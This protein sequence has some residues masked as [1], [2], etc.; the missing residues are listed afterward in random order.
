MML[1]ATLAAVLA[2][3]ATTLPA[4]ER[5]APLTMSFLPPELSQRNL[6]NAPDEPEKV[7]DLTVEGGDLELTDDHRIRYLRQDIRNYQRDD[8]DR[9]FD[10]VDALIT[11]LAQIDGGF[12][13]IDEALARI[14][15]HLHAGRLSA[16]E[17]SG[18]VPELAQR[19]GQMSNAQLLQLSWYY[20]DGVGVAQ[21]PHFAEQLLRDAAYGGHASALLEI[22]RLQMQG[23]MI[24]GW[25][26][27]LDLTV[28]MA[29]GGILGDMTP[30]V[31]NRAER[32]AREY[33][34][35]EIVAPN[36]DVALAWRRFAADM[37]GAEA[38]WRVVEH[39][40]SAP[41][42]VRDQAE[43][44]QYLRRA[45][46]LG[47]GIESKRRDRL[48]SSNAISAE[49]LEEMIG[50]NPP[51]DGRRAGR[52]LVP[53]L[54]LAVNID[55]V[56]ADEDSMYLEYLTEI[57]RMPEAPGQVFTRLGKETS[58][59]KGRWAAEREIMEF[60]EEAVRRGDGEGA[61]LL[62]ERLIR[63]RDD[64]QRLNRAENLLLDTVDRLGMASSM[65]RLDA[66][67]RCQVPQAPRLEE[68]TLWSANYHGSTWAPMSMS[69][70][71]LIGLDPYKDPEAIAKIQSQAIEGR[72]QGVANFAERLHSN[73]LASEPAMRLWADKLD[74]SDSAL[75]DFAKL[76]FELA[77]S[78]A[79]RN[80][81]VELFRRVYLNNGINT[82]LDL[83]IALIEDHARDPETADELVDL[84][85]RAGNR[86]EGA[87]IRLLSRLQADERDAREI[88]D[89]YAQ[90]IEDRG[91]F[92]ALMYAV[93]FLQDRSKLEDYVDRAVSLMNC[94]TKDTLEIADAYAIWQDA[95]QSYHWTRIGLYF[96]GG[97]SLSR[98]RLSNEQMAL[99][100][101]GRVA[102]AE[103][104]AV[105][106][107][108][109]GDPRAHRPL[110]VMAAD[111][112]RTSYDPQAAAS[113]LEAG[114]DAGDRAWALASYR[115][116][117]PSIREIVDERRDMASFWRAAAETGDAAARYEMG[118]LLRDRAERASDLSQSVRWLS[119][120]AEA[121]HDDAMVELGFALG[122]GL[123]V[124]RDA[125]SALMWLERADVAGHPRAPELADLI[126]AATR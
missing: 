52:S 65:D 78:P 118:M 3:T 2:L 91:D 58:T 75:E 41:A 18:L 120:A 105:R 117:G 48:I 21:D 61:Q 14:E 66:L 109:A 39:H 107:Q 55:G 97:R 62:A 121:G 71:D 37:G 79:E 15:L 104:L 42:E 7:D 82:A 99:Y 13:G 126:R 125:E 102:T 106:A 35:G 38:A 83:A 17:N 81:S 113:Y 87:A 94:T 76:E 46:D 59:R 36:P 27:P 6:C 64:T 67:Y 50:P 57:S 80:L 72:S 23:R 32:I 43:M 29:F 93:P 34:D 1:R 116:A 89:Q 111:P 9:Y 108:E 19:R 112:D 90:I 25:D 63:Y 49:D 100:R 115:R 45:V 74:R 51:D 86:G 28:T 31:C 16:L 84:L 26:A 24:Q 98:L 119:Q 95:A 47:L 11:R 110:F 10:F 40:L 12:A 73:G 8:A 69:A 77:T 88:Y 54:E 5:V 114:L 70:T 30:G 92:L 44:R 20:R 60:Y 22:A 56:E 33:I 123:G 85:T 103:E 68:A 96:E 124:P 122:M 101:K 53:Y 4:Q